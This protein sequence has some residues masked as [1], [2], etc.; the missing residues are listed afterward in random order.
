MGLAGAGW[1]GDNDGAGFSGKDK[2]TATGGPEV[3]AH[4]P[5]RFNS[6][7]WDPATG[8]YDM[9]FRDYSPGLNRFLT[10][11]MYNGA[12][13]DLRLGSDPWTGNR[14]AFAGG[15][16][17]TGIEYD[18]HCP[19]A[20]EGGCDTNANYEIYVPPAASDTGAGSSEDDSVSDYRTPA[21][22]HPDRILE[23][24]DGCS[25]GQRFGCSLPVGG[26]KALG[27]DGYGPY[28]K[29]TGDKGADFVFLLSTFGLP[30]GGATRGVLA[31]RATQAAKLAPAAKS[32]DN[33]LPTPQVGS[34][35]L[36]NLVDNLYTG[37]TNPNRV[38]NGTT[39]DAI[40]N[41]IAMGVPTRGRM[42]MTKGK[43]T[44]SGLKNWLRRNPDAAYYDRLVA[45]SLTD[46]LSLVLRG[47][48]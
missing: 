15:N 22:S 38:G 24:G 4:N 42:H 34:T 20:D 25:H 48:R 9:G 11:D 35:K 31:I 12:L 3:E 28:V 46:E 47:G 13:S 23:M 37:T 18:G 44:L 19:M 5:Y 40:L 6:K 41:E 27:D 2:A 21:R 43:E 39:M 32:V 10:R 16:P 8:G 36:Q 33:I 17:I 26:F 7:R 45:Q 30:G 29:T 14:Y 1:S